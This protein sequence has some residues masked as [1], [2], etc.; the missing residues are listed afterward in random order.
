MLLL[1]QLMTF[2]DDRNGDHSN[3]SQARRMSQKADR[4]FEVL[5]LRYERR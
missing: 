4:D 2:I 1:M 5:L 3:L